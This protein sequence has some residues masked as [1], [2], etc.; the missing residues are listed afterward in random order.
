VARPGRCGLVQQHERGGQYEPG[1]AQREQSGRRAVL[2]VDSAQ[3]VDVGVADYPAKAATA[4]TT[5]AV[6]KRITRSPLTG[7]PRAS[8]PR[9][10]R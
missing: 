1:H 7:P 2:P 3:P 10:H 8:S 9:R 5:A 4:Q 6:A